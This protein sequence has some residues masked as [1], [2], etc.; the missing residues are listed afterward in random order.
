M[1]TRTFWTENCI[2]SYERL[3]YCV[4]YIW[5][6]SSCNLNF[7]ANLLYVPCLN[8]LSNKSHSDYFDLLLSVDLVCECV[9]MEKQTILLKHYICLQI[10]FVN[11]D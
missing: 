7:N 4:A 5:N 11:S 6:S 1:C 2:L 10:R 3:V 9:F 8:I